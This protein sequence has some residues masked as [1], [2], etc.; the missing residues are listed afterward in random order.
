MN[1]LKELLFNS[2]NFILTYSILVVPIITGLGGAL[3][4]AYITFRFERYKRRK[5]CYLI[6]LNPIEQLV[7]KIVNTCSNA[8]VNLSAKTLPDLI[9]SVFEILKELLSAM[10]N[11]YKTGD[12]KLSLLIV[13]FY[14]NTFAMLEAI[15]KFLFENNLITE[16]LFKEREIL[17]SNFKSSFDIKLANYYNKQ[18][19]RFIKTLRSYYKKYHN[20]KVGFSKVISINLQTTFKIYKRIILLKV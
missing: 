11:L 7:D 13:K 4:G 12:K 20:E 18:Y 14:F 10:P 19:M 1:T 17:F 9:K 3:L 5:D 16:N 15:D 6:Y 8:L 2:R